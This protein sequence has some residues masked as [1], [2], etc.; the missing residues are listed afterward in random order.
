[1]RSSGTCCPRRPPTSATPTG[2]PASRTTG[3]GRTGRRTTTAEPSV[4]AVVAALGLRTQQVAD[5]DEQLDVGR[6]RGARLLAALAPLLHVLHRQ[7]DHEVDDRRD[8]DEVDRRVD[9]AAEVQE[10]GFVVVED[11][12]AEALR[13]VGAADRADQ[14][15]DEAGGE[16]RDDGRERRADDHRYGEVDDVA[17]HQ[18]VLETLEHLF[19]SRTGTVAPPPRSLPGDAVAR[20]GGR[21][22]AESNRYRTVQ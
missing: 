19:S 8:Q 6:L 17:A 3:T 9:H 22:L 18:E 12:V 10:R 15:L 11:L 21:G 2:A 4:A 1:M 13:G 16:R 14:R 5:L 20:L 7:H